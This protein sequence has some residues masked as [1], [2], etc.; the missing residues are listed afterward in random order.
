MIATLQLAPVVSYVVYDDVDPEF[1]LH[2]P[3]S[4]LA[5]RGASYAIKSPQLIK[6][7]QN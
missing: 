7:P 2:G 6:S 5:G 3:H 4:S 1:G